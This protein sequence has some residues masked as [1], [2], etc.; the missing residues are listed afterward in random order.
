MKESILHP[1]DQT[2]EAMNQN[3]P[4][5]FHYF[6]WDINGNAILK[7]DGKLYEVKPMDPYL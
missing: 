6:E 3:F 2:Y 1:V 5:T 4:I 7:H